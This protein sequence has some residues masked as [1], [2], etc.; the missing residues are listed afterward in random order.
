VLCNSGTFAFLIFFFFCKMILQIRRSQLINSYN[1]WSLY[2]Q[3]CKKRTHTLISKIYNNFGN[4]VIVL[5]KAILKIKHNYS[6][7]SWM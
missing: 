1:V 2:L 4:V 5:W 7:K 6:C 3:F